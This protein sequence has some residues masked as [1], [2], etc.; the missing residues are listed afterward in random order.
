MIRKI[1]SR[2]LATVKRAS[3]RSKPLYYLYSLTIG[4]CFTR[5]IGAVYAGFEEYRRRCGGDGGSE[6]RLRRNVHRLEKGLI[7]QPLRPVF[8]RD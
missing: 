7:M 5:E 6:F 8:A 2:L 4:R 1:I 3:V